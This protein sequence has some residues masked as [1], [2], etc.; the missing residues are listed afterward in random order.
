MANELVR[1]VTTV[2]V[3]TL[4]D[5][6]DFDQISEDM[7]DYLVGTVLKNADLAPVSEEFLS[8]THVHVSTRQS[9]CDYCVAHA[10]DEKS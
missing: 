3:K 4:G 2:R 6:V 9:N 10:M 5:G 8:A 7:G 1:V